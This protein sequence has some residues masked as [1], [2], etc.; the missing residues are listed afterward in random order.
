MI[1]EERTWIDTDPAAVFRFFETME[2][3]YE[4]WH[5]D[6][7][8]FRW[9]D[10]GELKEGAEAYFEERIGGELQKK[11]VVF[12]AIEPDRSLEFR[13]TGWSRLLLPS[14]SFSIE[15]DDDGCTI[16]QRIKVRTGPIGRF[17]NRREFE[18]VR[19]HMREEG[20]NL[21]RLLEN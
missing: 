9:V 19:A 21:K 15:P 8:L 13:P 17:L 20:Q 5:P 18:A 12:T 1:L 7:I 3:H 11:T 6:H 14:I 4:D 2:D 16:I 10:A